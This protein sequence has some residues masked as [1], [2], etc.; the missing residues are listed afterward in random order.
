MLSLHKLVRL[1]KGNCILVHFPVG[2]LGIF[3]YFRYSAI[4]IKGVR[5]GGSADASSD[6]KSTRGAKGVVAPDSVKKHAN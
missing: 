3:M 6:R 5:V 4:L 2:F 1:W